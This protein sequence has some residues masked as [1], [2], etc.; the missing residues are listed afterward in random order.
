MSDGHP[1]TKEEE[2]GTSMHD[3]TN[4][5]D[6]SMSD[7]VESSTESSAESPV[8]D[9]FAKSIGPFK[10][11]NELKGKIKENIIKEKQVKNIEKKRVA[12][13]DSILKNVKIDIPSILIEG[14]LDKMLSQIKSDVERS[15]VKFEDYLKQIN[16]T[17]EEIRKDMRP[18][19]Q[20]RAKT[21]IIFNQ[22]VNK[23]KLKP[24]KEILD[25]EVKEIL[26]HYP[27]ANEENARIY[28]T[29]VLLNAEVIKLF[30]SQK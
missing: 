25:K 28:V 11:L 6:T 24:N 1:E 27:E 3:D 17:E 14:E 4:M 15:G 10:D 16:K 20:K 22:I 12:T 8:D 7:P 2:A 9:E 23:E 19:A 18:D 26:K 21:Q 13:I 5:S 29:T 30:E